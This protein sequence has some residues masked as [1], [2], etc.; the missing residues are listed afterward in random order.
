MKHRLYIDADCK[1]GDAWDLPPAVSY[2][3]SLS[4]PMVKA[5]HNIPDFIQ[6]VSVL[7]AIQQAGLI[8]WALST[9]YDEAWKYLKDFLRV[10]PQATVAP[11]INKK[12]KDRSG[13]LRVDMVGISP[14]IIEHAKISLKDSITSH[15]DG[16]HT[17]KNSIEI[18][19]GDINGK[20]TD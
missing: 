10:M 18:N 9:A 13:I 15:P 19:F 12:V 11:V 4:E 8:D 17:T 3:V 16:S 20:N 14:D 5:G 1:I 6:S 7:I 2:E